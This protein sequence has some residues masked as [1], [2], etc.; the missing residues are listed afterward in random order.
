MDEPSV[1]VDPVS[2]EPPSTPVDGTSPRSSGFSLDNL[3]RG[4]GTAG[5][6]ARLIV[7]LAGAGGA[8]YLVL[9]GQGRVILTVMAGAW[10]FNQAGRLFK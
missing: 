4:E 3:L 7:Q 6:P 9:D 10:A 5:L 1:Q 2:A 8:M